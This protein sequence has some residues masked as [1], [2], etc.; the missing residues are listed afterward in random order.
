MAEEGAPEPTAVEEQNAPAPVVKKEPATVVELSN[1]NITPV[2][3]E[4]A[5]AVAPTDYSYKAKDPP[6]GQW[7]GS[8]W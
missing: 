6:L 3:S 7:R 5:G 8:L 2:Q 4:A 1:V